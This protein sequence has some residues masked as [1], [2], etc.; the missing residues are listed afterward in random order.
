MAAFELEYKHFLSDNNDIDFSKVKFKPQKVKSE[1]VL[2]AIVKFKETNKK[3][4]F[5]AKLSLRFKLKIGKSFFDINSDDYVVFLNNLYY[6][7][8]INEA[9]VWFNNS[10]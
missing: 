10:F 2:A 3:L 6:L 5:W 9:K 7:S 4:S 8:K 1:N